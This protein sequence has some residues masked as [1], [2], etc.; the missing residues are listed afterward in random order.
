M[1]LHEF[2]KETLLQLKREFRKHKKKLKVL[3]FISAQKDTQVEKRF[4]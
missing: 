2:I 3:A 4:Y 1:E